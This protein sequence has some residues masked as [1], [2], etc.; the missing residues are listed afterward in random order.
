[1]RRG[2]TKGLL[3]CHL[4][5][6]VPRDGDARM[7]VRDQIVRWAEGETLVFD[8]THPHE[9]WNEARAA[10]IVLRLRFARPCASPAARS[11]TV[12]CACWAT[13]PNAIDC[14]RETHPFPYPA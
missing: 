11:P 13:R 3:T 7:R 12:C 4:G 1:M 14:S 5:L 9:L 8:D 2:T 10:R 6:A